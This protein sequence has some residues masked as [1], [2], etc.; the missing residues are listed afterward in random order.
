MSTSK[1]SEARS[2]AWVR[3]TCIGVAVVVVSVA[4]VKI[5]SQADGANKLKSFAAVIAGMGGLAKAL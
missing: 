3:P 5:A 2:N 4:C 1:E